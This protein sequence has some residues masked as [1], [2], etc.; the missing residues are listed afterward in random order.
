MRRACAPQNSSGAIIETIDSAELHWGPM[1]TL[2]ALPTATVEGERRSCRLGIVGGVGPQASVELYMR[3]VRAM[4]LLR[5]G[6]IPEIV[7]HSL[8]VTAHLERSFASGAFGPAEELAVRRLL[9]ESAALLRDAGVDVIA[10]PCNTLH[11]YLPELLEEFDIP[12]LD[13]IAATCET[14]WRRGLRRA[15]LVATGATAVSETYPKAAAEVGVELLTPNAAD[16]RRIGD[17]IADV[18]ARPNGPMTARALISHIA[19]HMPEDVDAL[20]I[21]C[22]DLSGCV[23]A[24][25]PVQVVDSLACLAEAT[26]RYLSASAVTAGE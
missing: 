14:L 8:P 23:P 12:F 18:L 21:G 13:M 2:P 9:T 24:N 5:G 4:R 17:A 22:T 10:M 11:G 7:M 19:A 16:Q 3:V 25:L 1:S 26:S 15:M 20:V 6:P